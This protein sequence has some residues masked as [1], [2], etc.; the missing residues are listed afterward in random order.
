MNCSEKAN[1][2]TSN[3]QVREKQSR[4]S[5]IFGQTLFVN[6]FSWKETCRGQ[7][8]VVTIDNYKVGLGTMS[9]SATDK[10]PENER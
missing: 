5:P 9:L 10:S 6:V 7:A 8:R 1:A 4:H 2:G 3:E